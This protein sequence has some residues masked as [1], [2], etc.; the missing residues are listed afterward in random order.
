ME[1][2]LYTHAQFV[3]KV[4]RE[5]QAGPV[6]NIDGVECQRGKLVMIAN[7]ER[8]EIN[9]MPHLIVIHVDEDGE[10]FGVIMDRQYANELLDHLGPHPL[11]EEFFRLH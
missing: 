3:E 9:G 11:V 7:V 6:I 1:R 2:K 8:E 4:K 5:I 10:E